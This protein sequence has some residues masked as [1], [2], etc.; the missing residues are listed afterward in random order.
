MHAFIVRPFG[1][2]KNIDFENVE[3]QLISPALTR[4][5]ITGR[6]TMDIARAGNIRSDMFQLLLTA[7]LVIADI[8]IHNANVF[9]ELGVRHAL[10]NKHTLLLR[11]RV[12]EVPFDLR[13]DRYQEYDPTS[14]QLGLET[15]VK[16]IRETLGGQVVDSPV[17][18]LVP[19]LP[20]I[21]PSKFIV[22]PLD[23]REEVERAYS[24]KFCGDLRFL[25]AETDGLSWKREGLRLVGEAQFRL[26]DYKNAAGTWMA[27]RR[28]LPDDTE[29]N[30]R[31]G[32]IQQKQQDLTESS[33]SLKRIAVTSLSAERLAEMQA[34]L[35]SNAKALWLQ[36]WKS[37]PAE[38][39]AAAA[40]QSP[41]LFDSYKE[42]RSGFQA[43]LN[44]FYSG[45]NALAMLTVITSL[46]ER[47]PDAWKQGF[48]DEV[49]ADFELKKYQKERDKLVGAVGLSIQAQ[50]E[51]DERRGQVDPWALVS[52]ADFACLVGR[53][54]VAQEYKKALSKL[55]DFSI[56]SVRR[57]LEIYQD[58]KLLEN[59]V[60]AAL[61]TFPSP[62][63]PSISKPRVQ[64]LLFTGHR[65]D[66]KGRVTPRF[67]A[68]KESVAEQAIS[69]KVKAAVR[70]GERVIAVSG[71]ASGGDLLF[72][73]ACE[74]LGIERQLYLIIPRDEYVVESV[75]PAG[76]NWVERFNHQFETATTRTYQKSKEVPTWLQ[77]KGAYT[78]WERSNLW[79][80]H[81]AL[82]YGAENVT[83]IALW[84][85]QGEDGP[86][87]TKHMVETADSSGAQTI[88]IDTK[89]LF[90]QS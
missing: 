48:D 87:G 42:Y 18:D 83:L 14:P 34:L 76:P 59:S 73:E 9:Y 72:L 61:T 69:S 77:P 21:D 17:F 84:D 6:T 70:E 26:K 11:A 90:G 45:L 66:A 51:R 67:P 56:E 37:R 12:D 60:T 62:P 54:S 40:L 3:Q 32:T 63:P 82:W 7:D 24:N 85:G 41:Y 53:K 58:L 43:D 65:I 23:F 38:E 35:G 39:Q 71:G 78:V 79:M 28:E 16:A 20:V 2:Q 30:L 52:L 64:V 27:I 74:K 15:L 86:G 55:D 89:K 22:V 50:V 80:L 5:A 13:T 8:S 46:A 10:R 68:D 4:L 19:G 1:K 88:I 49:T 31:L 33:L 81:N 44:H 36:Q 47:L 57:Q 25:A 75:S 29:A